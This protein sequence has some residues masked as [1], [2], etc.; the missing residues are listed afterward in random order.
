MKVASVV[1]SWKRKEVTVIRLNRMC[2]AFRT[3]VMKGEGISCLSVNFFLVRPSPFP[4]SFPPPSLPL[5]FLR[6]PFPQPAPRTWRQREA[7]RIF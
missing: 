7:T 1:R 6:P 4:P 2:A 3:D 5:R